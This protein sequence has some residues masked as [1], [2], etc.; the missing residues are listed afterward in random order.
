MTI[1]RDDGL[2]TV[3]TGEIEF[4]NEPIN[5]ML[6]DGEEERALAIALSC[7]DWITLVSG[8]TNQH[9]G[10]HNAGTTATLAWLLDRVGSLI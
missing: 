3:C 4:P 5:L 1:S 9:Y 2:M 8:G 10:I 6:E 7:E